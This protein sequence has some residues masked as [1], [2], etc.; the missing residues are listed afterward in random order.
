MSAKCHSRHFA[1][2]RIASLFDHI[3]SA[4]EQRRRHR[5]PERLGGPEID[6]QLELGCAVDWH[7]CRPGAF[8]EATSKDSDASIGIRYVVAVADQAAGRWQVT[9]RR[10]HRKP[11]PCR[12]DGELP[13]TCRVERVP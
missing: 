11:M 7:V 3:V 4:G 6:N 5:K 13:T 1:T 9:G 12:Q 2:Q 8:E 10:H